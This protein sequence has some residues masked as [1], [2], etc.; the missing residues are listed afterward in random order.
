MG[1]HACLLLKIKVLLIPTFWFWIARC[2]FWCLPCYSFVCSLAL[3]NLY[4]FS[5]LFSS[6][7]FDSASLNSSAFYFP[8]LE[9]I[10]PTVFVLF[11][12]AQEHYYWCIT[13][14]HS[15]HQLTKHLMP[16]IIPTLINDNHSLCRNTSKR[17]VTEN[18][19]SFIDF[20]KSN[21]VLINDDIKMLQWPRGSVFRCSSWS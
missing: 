13:P 1:S 12:R 6:Q 19:V 7:S 20:L 18:F 3:F 17:Y 15:Y 16:F 11:S 2:K 8:V 5:Y 14:I 9:F 21:T 4:C 10:L